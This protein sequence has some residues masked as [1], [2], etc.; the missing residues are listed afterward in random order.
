MLFLHAAERARAQGATS[1]TI[2]ADPQAEAFYRHMG[3]V[4]F[5]LTKSEIDGCRR[6]LPLLAF[7]LTNSGP[8][9]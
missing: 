4:R 5:G 2:E 3:A 7:N 1:L 8:L 9:L 6:D